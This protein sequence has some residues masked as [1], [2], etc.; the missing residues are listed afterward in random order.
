M[1][2]FR[3]SSSGA[4]SVLYFESLLITSLKQVNKLKVKCSLLNNSKGKANCVIKKDNIKLPK[5][6]YSRKQ[7][8][9]N[10]HFSLAAKLS[11]FL[12]S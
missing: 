11:S 4:V 6:F 3:L 1:E 10:E 7:T 12:W 5:D 2:L 8:V 9:A